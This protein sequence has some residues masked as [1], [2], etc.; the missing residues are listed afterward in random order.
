M[1]SE[2]TYEDLGSE[3]LD[4]FK[5]TLKGTEKINNA[6]CFVI[7][8][9]PAS[10]IILKQSGYSKRILYISKDHYVTI[11][12][13][14]YD[15]EGNLHKQLS[16]ENIKQIEGTDKWRACK[17]SMKN[18][19]TNYSTLLEFESFTINK[20]ISPDVFTLRNLESVN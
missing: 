9:E 2:F 11:R 3:K 12:I 16:S 14:Y 19:Q 7:L 6:E 8:A 5:Y 10:D 18:L 20:G 1:S 13:D 4:Q 17:L 15:K